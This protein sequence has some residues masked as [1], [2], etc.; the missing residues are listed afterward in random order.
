MDIGFHRGEDARFYLDTRCRRVAV[1]G[2]PFFVEEARTTFAE[3]LCPGFVERNANLSGTHYRTVD[4]PAIRFEDVI[5]KVGIPRYLKVDIERLDMLCIRALRVFDERPAFVSLEWGCVESG[6]AV[7]ECFRGARRALVTR[8]P[9]L[10]RYRPNDK[11]V[12][13]GAEVASG[14]SLRRYAADLEAEWIFR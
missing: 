11:P 3:E 2:D 10:R 12:S 4:V 14:R 13:S 8:L 1:E 9:P 6:H 7:R 5:A